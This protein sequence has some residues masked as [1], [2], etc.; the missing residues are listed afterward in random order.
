[1][2]GPQ[3]DQ[4]LT[5]LAGGLVLLLVFVALRR[6][7]KLAVSAWLFVICFVP[8]WIGQTVVG[9]YFPAFSIISL[10]A[11]V[12]LVTAV[13]HFRWSVVDAVFAAVLA[14][15]VVEYLLGLTTRSGTFD[16]V[17]A[18]GAAFLLGRVVTSVL[19]PRWVYG[20]FGVFFSLVAVLAIVEFVTSFNVFTTYLGN[21]NSNYL[22]WGDLQPRG[23]ITRAEGAF[24]HSIALG[25]SLGIA[26]AMTMGSRFRP[27]VKTVMVGLMA[28]GAVVGFSRAG[29]LT[30]GL[31]VLLSCLF[32]REPLTRVYRIGLLLLA[33]AAGVGVFLAVQD[34]FVASGSE[35][36][37]SA[38]YRGE[39]LQLVRFIEPFGVASN[40]QVTTNREVSVGEFAS[41]DNALLLFGLIYGWVP[42]LLLL[43][44]TVPA[45]VYL[46]LRKR[47]TPAVIAVLAAFPALLT[48]ALI[49]QYAAVF[50][51][52]VG[53]AVS[54][55]VKANA[56][57]A[58]PA[59]SPEATSLL[60]ARGAH[61]VR[62]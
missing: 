39:L 30:A 2:T 3:L 9:P 44:V 5:A 29:M 37:G 51:F 13:S 53:L 36:A 61:A 18:W 57:S 41:I 33:A 27:W 22:A 59:S 45:A 62:S 6:S 10:V 15:V 1:M 21:D 17:T 26:A 7:P 4:G 20:A 19:D 28:V 42:E 12:S 35:A 55:Q 40:Y 31:A 16:L 11:A 32:L 47:A 46:L 54:T 23:G 8:V 25:T 60:P 14:I 38:S 48:V 52:A 24:G 50:W 34:V 58:D 49:T 56:T 43:L